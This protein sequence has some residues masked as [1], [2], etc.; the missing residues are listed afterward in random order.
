MKDSH[1]SLD[2]ALSSKSQFGY[3]AG[4]DHAGSK[5]ILFDSF[6]HCSFNFTIYNKSFN[7]FSS[8]FSL[9]FLIWLS[10]SWLLWS[11]AAWAWHGV[12]PIWCWW[13]QIGHIT[14]IISNLSWRSISW[15]LFNKIKLLLKL[16]PRLLRDILWCKATVW[17]LLGIYLL[18]RW[19]GI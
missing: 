1:S 15:I 3:E 13:H 2:S 8:S 12:P 4:Y 14:I 18:L 17:V 6:F 9:I 10:A 11:I 19:I 5:W 16:L 7:Y